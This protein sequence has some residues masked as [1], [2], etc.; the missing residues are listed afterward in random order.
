[1][2]VRVVMDQLVMSHTEEVLEVRVEVQAARMILVILVAQHNKDPVQVLPVM[3]MRVILIL[4]APRFDLQVVVVVQVQSV[5]LHQVVRL[6]HQEQVV[7]V[8]LLR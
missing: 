1:M 4:V 7:Q 2:A 8:E 3:E 5:Y 6:L